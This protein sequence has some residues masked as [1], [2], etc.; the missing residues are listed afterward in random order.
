MKQHELI[1]AANTGIHKTQWADSPIWSFAFRPGFLLASGASLLAVTNWL[2]L[3]NGIDFGFQRAG[4]SSLAWHAHE[5]VFG[6]AATVAM[7]FIL[8]AVQT[9]TGLRSING[10]FLMGLTALW[11]T[12]RLTS[13]FAPDH[14]GFLLP[15]AQGAWWLLGIYILTKL[16]IKSKSRRNYIFIPLFAAIASIN[17]AVILFEFS[18][19]SAFAL[20]L[21]KTAILSFGLLIS[22]IGG[23]IIPLFSNNAIDGLSIGP[24]PQINRALLI[25]SPI[26]I[27]AYFTSYFELLPTTPAP[28]M[29][30]IGLLHIVRLSKWSGWKTLKHPLLWSLHLT[31]FCLAIGLIGLGA[32]Y[33]FESLTFSSALHIITIGS[34]GGMILS[35][36]S[37]VSLGHTNRRIVST[38]AVSVALIALP[39]AALVRF[40]LVQINEPLLAWNISGLLWSAAIAV[41]LVNYV[42]ILTQPSQHS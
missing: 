25:L 31:Y 27:F 4:L 30:A 11:M 22:L 8:T 29:F 15:L 38:K 37:R 17:I 41:F 2:L 39:I 14:L 40:I 24:T 20:H 12:A 7:A 1:N 35:M 5:M 21:T 19:N 6:F 34:I 23:R 42:P 32:S 28:I 33:Y 26:G 18:D 36:M 3:L 9:W 16:I 10:T 13:W